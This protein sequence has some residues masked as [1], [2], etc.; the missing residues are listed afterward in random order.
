M[1]NASSREP[2]TGREEATSRYDAEGLA[3]L[4]W[5]TGAVALSLTF[6]AVMFLG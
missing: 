3:Q 6:A 2:P 4:R 5:L 1:F